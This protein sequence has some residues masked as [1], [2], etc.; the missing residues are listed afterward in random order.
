MMERG[1]TIIVKSYLLWQDPAP[2][3]PVTK[4]STLN[5]RDDLDRPLITAFSNVMI[6][7]A[8]AVAI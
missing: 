7:L 2:C 5:V 3:P 6:H 8:L 4:S 1:S